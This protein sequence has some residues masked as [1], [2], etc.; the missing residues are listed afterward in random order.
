MTNF[1]WTSRFIPTSTAVEQI[2]YDE[3]SK[4]LAV[5]LDG[6]YVYEYNDVPAQEYRA[7]RDAR[8]VGRYYAKNIK[9]NYGPA[10]PLGDVDDVDFTQGVSAPDMGA[11]YDSSNRVFQATGVRE[12]ALGTPKALTLSSDAVITYDTPP[13]RFD[14]AQP[15]VVQTQSSRFT[16]EFTDGTGATRHYNTEAFDDTAALDSLT[17]VANMLDVTL[18]PV[19]VTRYL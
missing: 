12:G 2:H 13:E 8:S 9:R 18:T 6:G 16:V 17:D 7:L 3:A 10:L 11:V 1:N 14:L 15:K 5:T 19:A 4:R